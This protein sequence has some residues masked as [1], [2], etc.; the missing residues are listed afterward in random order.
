MKKR[1]LKPEG[2]WSVPFEDPK[3]WRTGIYR[4]EFINV[5]EIDKV[6]KHSCP[7]LFICQEGTMGLL[8]MDD[9]GNEE[10]LTMEPGEALSV[11]KWHNG[12]SASK[13]GYFIVIERTEIE[14]TFTQRHEG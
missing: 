13:E 6:E 10:V 5:D 7:E 3:Y 12:F 14:T 11:E 9:E 1:Q 8:L 4:P 2:R